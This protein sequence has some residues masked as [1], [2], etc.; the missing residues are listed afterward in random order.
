MKKLAALLSRHTPASA[1]IFLR[2]PTVTIGS[3][4]RQTLALFKRIA[5]QPLIR[6]GQVQGHRD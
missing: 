1:P 5:S 2:S 4:P 3:E 6:P